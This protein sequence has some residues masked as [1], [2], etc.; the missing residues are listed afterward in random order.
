MNSCMQMDL[1]CSLITRM[2]NILKYDFSKVSSQ[3]M[4]VT[5]FLFYQLLSFV[6][7]ILCL[8]LIK[9]LNNYAHISIHLF[10]LMSGNI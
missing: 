9:Y 7:Q 8:K 1:L 3:F 4:Y 2:C 5:L 10:I 6:V